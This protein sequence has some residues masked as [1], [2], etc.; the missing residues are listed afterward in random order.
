MN[1]VVKQL[2]QILNSAG[3]Q[4]DEDGQLGTQTINALQDAV[5]RGIIKIPQ[6]V[7]TKLVPKKAT[8]YD[9]MHENSNA[10]FGQ[11]PI[12]SIQDWG[13]YQTIVTP[14][15]K[16][17]A[18]QDVI[19][20]LYTGNVPAYIEN[21]VLKAGNVPTN[22]AYNDYINDNALANQINKQA[23]DEYIKSEYSPER[24]ALIATGVG[25]GLNTASPSNWFGA[26]KGIYDGKTSYEIGRGIVEGNSGVVSDE[27]MSEHPYIGNAVNMGFDLLAYNTPA[28][29]RTVSSMFSPS[30]IINSIGATYDGPRYVVDR[31]GVGAKSSSNPNPNNFRKLKNPDKIEGLPT[32]RVDQ[33]GEQIGRYM[34]PGEEYVELRNQRYIQQSEG[35]SGYN[36]G[37]RR[38]DNTYG[39]RGPKG[40]IRSESY[41][42][43]STDPIYGVQEGDEYRIIRTPSF[44]PEPTFVELDRSLLAPEP[45]FVELNRSL[46]ASEPKFVKLNIPTN[47]SIKSSTTPIINLATLVRSTA[48]SQVNP[49]V[50]HWTTI[51]ASLSLLP[52][53]EGPSIVSI[54]Y[55]HDLVRNFHDDEWI[56][57]YQHTPEGQIFWHN[58]KSYIKQGGG[59]DRF[60]R[61]QYNDG[62]TPMGQSAD[63]VY[64]DRGVPV[65]E[66]PYGTPVGITRNA[67]ADTGNIDYNNAVNR[68]TGKQ[69]KSKVT[70]K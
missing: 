67:G 47:P 54:P 63:Q 10:D 36:G 57:K 16:R 9:I 43:P 32:Q 34:T 60:V 23:I 53:V 2:Q 59:R 37:T 39:N 7:S 28:L 1:E 69:E 46:L 30:R 21:G 66:V 65:V 48:S 4:L 56:Q 13:N 18:V 70:N 6:Q 40:E 61:M 58:G 41:S 68:N 3:Y 17:I 27:Y 14:S 38:G 44:K 45:K 42:G 12:E 19:K 62:Y 8:P 49:F 51:G 33:A 25:P 24:L 55:H 35:R 52:K 31:R 22:L 29:Y 64:F 20:G 26:A 5:T 15:G 50:P 11:Y